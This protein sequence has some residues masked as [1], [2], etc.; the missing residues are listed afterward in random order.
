MNTV[1]EESQLFIESNQHIFQQPR[2]I[3]WQI[4]Q[5]ILYLIGSVCFT[6]GSCMYFTKVFHS[7]PDA[8]VI[9]GWSFTIG[10]LIFLFA[11][12]QDWW[13]YRTG[14]CYSYKD[15]RNED[16]LLSSFSGRLRS[17]SDEDKHSKIE[18]N[19]FGSLCGIVFY[20]AGSIFFIPIFVNYLA[21]GEWFFIFGSTF[22][23][24]SLL[25]KM[26]RSAC[27]NSDQKFH[28]KTL[29]NDIPMLL[30]DIFSTIGNLCFFIGTI[31]FLSYINH[32]DFDENRAAFFFVFGS[33]CFLLSSLILQYTICCR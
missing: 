20:L 8:L 11:D 23:Y 21:I 31:L 15:Y 27:Q 16:I 26:Y 13:D 12:L 3:Q 1:N 30:M 32:S 7:Y 33:G 25:W 5:G 10:S 9:G 24:L 28:M 6:G 22:C 2:P 17:S 4:F 29:L 14:Y 19:V 18:S